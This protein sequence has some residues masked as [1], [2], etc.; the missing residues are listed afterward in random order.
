VRV[1]GLVLAPAQKHSE[2]GEEAASCRP[3]KPEIVGSSPTPATM[4]IEVEV[5]LEDAAVLIAH[6]AEHL[7]DEQPF[8]LRSTSRSDLFEALAEEIVGHGAGMVETIKDNLRSAGL[9]HLVG[10]AQERLLSDSRTLE[11]A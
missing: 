3:H 7:I 4:K 5:S 6:H 9:F 1:A 2:R 11:Q 8:W 10:Q